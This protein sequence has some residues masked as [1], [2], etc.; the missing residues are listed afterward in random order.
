VK[1]RAL[2]L[3]LTK[4]EHSKLNQSALYLKQ[5][6]ARGGDLEARALLLQRPL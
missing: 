2:L 5:V 1:A 4:T 3:H 6:R